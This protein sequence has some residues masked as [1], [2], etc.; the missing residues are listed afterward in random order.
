MTFGDTE[1]SAF[2]DMPGL[3]VGSG[4]CLVCRTA[5]NEYYMLGYGVM[6]RFNSL[7]EEKP[8]IEYLSIEE[9]EFVDGE[10]KLNRLLNGDEEHIRIN[11]PTILKI[12]T[13]LF[14]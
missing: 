12:R 10:W 7:D 13:H 11:E 2:F 14:N 9:G 3:N 4:A 6:P 8:F 1:I 5:P